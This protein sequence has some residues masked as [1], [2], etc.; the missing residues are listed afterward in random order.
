MTAAVVTAARPRTADSDASSLAAGCVEQ[1]RGVDLRSAR[2]L[3]GAA[4]G[5]PKDLVDE[6]ALGRSKPKGVIEPPVGEDGNQPGTE[7]LR[8]GIQRHGQANREEPSRNDRA[9]DVAG[10]PCL[11]CE[12]SESDWKRTQREPQEERDSEEVRN[13]RA[14]DNPV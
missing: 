1:A 9:G 14:K 5:S 11:A 6:Y 8:K 13:R 12:I 10:Q 3:P 7:D 4:T 2:P